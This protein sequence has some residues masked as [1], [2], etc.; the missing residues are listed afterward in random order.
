MKY[1]E[2]SREA[3]NESPLALE[4]KMKRLE[5]QAE[6]QRKRN[7]SKKPSESTRMALIKASF[8]LKLVRDRIPAA[9]HSKRE[10]AHVKPTEKFRE[11]IHEGV[12]AT[13]RYNRDGVIMEAFNVLRLPARKDKPTDYITVPFD[14]NDFP[15]FPG[16]AKF[17]DPIMAVTACEAAVSNF[18]KKMKIAEEE[19]RLQAEMIDSPVP[20]KKISVTEKKMSA[21]IQSAVSNVIEDTDSLEV[22]RLPKEEEKSLKTADSQVPANQITATI[23]SEPK[24]TEKTADDSKVTTVQSGVKDTVTAVKAAMAETEVEPDAK[25]KTVMASAEIAKTETGPDFAPELADLFLKLKEQYRFLASVL[26][27]YEILVEGLPTWSEIKS[28][29]TT[30]TLKRALKL[31]VPV[32]VMVPPLARREMIMAMNENKGGK[33]ECH[34]RAIVMDRVIDFDND[35]IWNAD[36]DESEEKG[37]TA[38]IADGVEEVEDPKIPLDEEELIVNS[39]GEEEI[40]TVRKTNAEIV[41]VW[42]AKFAGI[43]LEAMDNVR[44]YLILA[45]LRMAEGKPLDTDT[46]TALIN[47]EKNQQHDFYIAN[48]RYKDGTV[49]PNKSILDYNVSNYLRMRGTV[50]LNLKKKPL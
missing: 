31:K 43:K 48:C 14:D 25:Q 10:K 9:D 22:I 11:V 8:Q 4:E 46:F 15:G 30:E 33:D 12:Y 45:L 47:K 32:L 21:L 38:E 13:I 49:F 41:D 7:K 24:A 19:R 16:F 28:S 17:R 23:H 3:M 39:K 37:Y 26:K 40:V 18:E 27:K 42:L 29:L 44:S 35:T 20:V 1:D 50:K 6:E 34:H 2:W 36:K 5:L